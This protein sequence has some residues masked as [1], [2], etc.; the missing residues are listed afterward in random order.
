MSVSAT[1]TPP[2]RAATG[3]RP[4]WYIPWLF[5]PPFLAMLTANGFLIHYAFSSFSGLTSQHASAEGANY[6]AAIAAAR[7][8]DA[9]GW[10]AALTFT[11]PQG[12]TGVVALV[13]HDRE[14]RPLDGA[15]VTAAFIRPTSAGADQVFPLRALGDGR[16]QA[17]VMLRLPGIWDLRLIAR[18]PDGN[19][20]KVQRV[21]V[22]G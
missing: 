15:D 20:Q 8:Q 4:G 5:V 16:Y 14:G 21:K 7:A 1:L 11:N 10:Q 22:T 3:R 12:L 13:L 17:D 6:N 2:V 9:R 19:W 18:H